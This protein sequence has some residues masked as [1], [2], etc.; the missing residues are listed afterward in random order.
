MRTRHGELDL[1]PVELYRKYVAY[2]RKFV[3]P[4]LTVEA[5]EILRRFH[6]EWLEKYSSSDYLP[7]TARQLESLMRLAEA[8]AKVDLREVITQDDA[9]DVVELMKFSLIDTY[10][11]EEGKIDIARSQNGAGLTGRSQVTIFLYN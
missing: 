2:A 1:L 7:I 9:H 3:K 4:K 6:I 10:C 5:G 8:R 11:D